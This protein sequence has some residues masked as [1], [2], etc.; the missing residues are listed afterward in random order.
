M[1]KILLTVTEA[2]YAFNYSTA[3]IYKLINSGKLPYVKK[4]KTYLIPY[5]HLLSLV[6][7][8]LLYRKP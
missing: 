8:S 4:G 3:A 7:R 2:A 5:N 6:E 1:Q